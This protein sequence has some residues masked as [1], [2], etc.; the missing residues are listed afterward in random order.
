MSPHTANARQGR[1][2]E[3]NER[4]AL[5][6]WHRD[7]PPRSGQWS[8]RGL[9]ARGPALPAGTQGWPIWLSTSWEDSGQ[10]NQNLLLGSLIW[11]WILNSRGEEERLGLFLPYK[12]QM[13]RDRQPGRRRWHRAQCGARLQRHH[14][15]ERPARR[16]TVSPTPNRERLQ[17]TAAG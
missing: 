17:D 13:S 12:C 4:P 14:L 9:A 11:W 15:S 8:Q 6:P 10:E 5:P 2:A 7:L 1:P 16:R 3:P